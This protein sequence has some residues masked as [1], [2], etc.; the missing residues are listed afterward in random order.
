MGTIHKALITTL[1]VEFV[2]LIVFY[3]LGNECGSACDPHNILNP[4][5]IIIKTEAMRVCTLQCVYQPHPTFWFALD[6]LI[7]TV[8][9][10][11]IKRIRVKQVHKS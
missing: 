11:V 4:F 6:L 3:N 9:I 10:L 1:G 7:L 8:I 2:A 5:G